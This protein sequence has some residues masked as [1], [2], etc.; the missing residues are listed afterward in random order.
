MLYTILVSLCFHMVL[1]GSQLLLHQL[2][3]N[4]LLLDPILQGR[5]R[6][7]RMDI[8]TKVT[9]LIPIEDLKR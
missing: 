5:S 8:K 1:G 9:W 4:S 3:H 6:A 7:H 2:L